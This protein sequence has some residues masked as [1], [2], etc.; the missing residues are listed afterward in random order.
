MRIFKNTHHLSSSTQRAFVFC[1][2]PFRIPFAG[3]VDTC[4]FDKTG[5]LTSDNFIVRGVA[6]PGMA[7]PIAHTDDNDNA[8]DQ[9][10]NDDNANDENNNDN[11]DGVGVGKSVSNVS[12][13]DGDDN[14]AVAARDA[15][16]CSLPTAPL[17]TR[18]VIG[19]W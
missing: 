1:T 15:A 13:G 7:L 10:N 8:N 9:N 12:V 5:T 11:N 4:C 3:R 6:L 14:D 19:V 16:L 17:M 18:V 2:E